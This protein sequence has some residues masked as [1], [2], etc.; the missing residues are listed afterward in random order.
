MR[1]ASTRCAA[2]LRAGAVSGQPA[3]VGPLLVTGRSPP[4]PIHTSHSSGR[5]GRPDTLLTA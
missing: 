5:A 3:L 2:V 1:T 4:S